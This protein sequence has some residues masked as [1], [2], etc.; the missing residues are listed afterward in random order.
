ME[1]GVV[2]SMAKR[3]AAV[4]YIFRQDVMIAQAKAKTPRG[5]LYVLRQVTADPHIGDKKA[6]AEAIAKMTAELMDSPE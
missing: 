2:E 5:A 3:V 6:R 4:K 1:Q